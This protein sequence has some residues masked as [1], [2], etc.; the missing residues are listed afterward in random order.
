ME[1]EHKQMLVAV[2]IVEYDGRFLVV[3]RVSSI[4]LWHG[5]WNLPGGKVQRGESPEAAVRREVRE[6]T[7]VDIGTPELLGIY[8]HHWELPA[9]TQQTFLA[10]YRAPALHDRVVLNEKENDAYRWVTL[11][12]FYALPEHLDGNIDMLR[13]LYEPKML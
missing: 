13:Q 12:E 10:T 8:T 5:K 7:G 9:S 11:H 1:R 4:P 6:E 3:R 2:G